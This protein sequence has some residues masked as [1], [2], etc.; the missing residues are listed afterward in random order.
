MLAKATKCGAR[1]GL[2][3]SLSGLNPIIVWLRIRLKLVQ[4]DF[5]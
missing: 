1:T 4:F 3:S 2:K 5:K